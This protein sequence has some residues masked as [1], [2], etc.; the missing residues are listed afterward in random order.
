METMDSFCRAM[1]EREQARIDA[2]EERLRDPVYRAAKEAEAAAR[3]AEE[4]S[5]R[6]RAGR[7]YLRAVGVPAKD[8]DVLLGQATL[9]ET[10]AIAV[11]RE[12][13]ASD[14]TVLVMSGMRGCGKTLAA[15]WI[16]NEVPGGRFM[17][18]TRFQRLSRYDNESMRSV[19][20]AHLLVIDDL[21]ME[22]SDAKGSFAAL[23]DGVFNARYAAQLRTVITT[24]VTA[25]TFRERY[26]ERV[27][28]RIRE[29]GRFVELDGASLRGVK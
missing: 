20:E 13:L 27:A 4:A 12:W 1:L 3:L 26:G 5:S 8:A 9:M 11:A 16:V 28:D 18:V 7:K 23:F 2:E 24:N 22:F 17:D 10:P 19:E 21:G 29:V 14:Q 25:V 15:G 6:L